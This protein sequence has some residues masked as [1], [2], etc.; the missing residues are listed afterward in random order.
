MSADSVSYDFLAP[1]Q[2]ADELGRLGPYRVLEVLGQ[3]GMGVVF[4]AEDLKLHRTV[5]LK[6]MLPDVARR[7]TAR[8]RFLR[9]ARAAASIEHDHIVTI[10]QVDEDRG[11]PF[12]AMQL[13]KGTSLEG[14][15]KKKARCGQPGAGL[16]ISQT[17]KLGR[18]IARGLGAAHERGLIHRDIKPANIWLDAAAGGRVK[19]LDFGLARSANDVQLTQSGVIMGTPLYMAPE[20]ARGQPVDGRADLYSL[21]CILYRLCT[22]RLPFDGDEPMAVMLQAVTE[23]AP[24]IHTFNPHVPPALCDLITRLMAKNP[25]DRPASARAVVAALDAIAAGKDSNRTAHGALDAVAS[26]EAME[27]TVGLAAVP[28]TPPGKRR[29][30]LVMAGAVVV[31]GV[32]GVAILSALP[33]SGPTAATGIAPTESEPVAVLPTAKKPDP[34]PP[35]PPMPVPAPP[36]PM[37]GQQPRYVGTITSQKGQTRALAFSPDGTLL[38]SSGADGSV[39]LHLRDRLNH[40]PLARAEGAWRLAYSPDGKTL[41]C[42]GSTGKI[43]LINTST[44]AVTREM[45]HHHL[46]IYG[47]AYRPGGKTL[48]AAYQNGHVNVVLWDLSRKKIDKADWNIARPP[49]RGLPA[50]VNLSADGDFLA[51]G[52]KGGAIEVWDVST[53]EKVTV[54]KG[55]TGEPGPVVFSPDGG[56]VAAGSS[57]GT[58]AVWQRVSGERL[59]SWKMDRS[60]ITSVA[61]YPNGKLVAASTW[62][63]TVMLW[64][65]ATGKEWT[66]LEAQRIGVTALAFSADGRTLAT[67]SRDASVKLW[68]LSK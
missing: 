2:A 40:E 54:C 31:A 25:A 21:G 44:G 7:A 37:P 43:Q 11:V 34:P 9:E 15:L 17:I 51:V 19:I 12:L 20:Q 67:G 8:E 68:D 41:A 56:L 50:S 3:G 4:R 46:P 63:P 65:I 64:E 55:L 38:A 52:G 58:V 28:R 6:V 24:P 49:A 18:E 29:R 61:F 13:L 45:Q 42:G 60:G 5:A 1:A 47:L 14:L 57:N 59:A 26:R 33:R 27:T 39:Q 22:G 30:W 48:A 36:L 62:L 53:G 23:N 10:Y 32:A 16:T 35:Q 66:R